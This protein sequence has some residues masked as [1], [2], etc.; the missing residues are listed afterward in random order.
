M[1]QKTIDKIRALITEAR[2]ECSNPNSSPALRQTLMQ[3]KFR[4]KI[5][6]DELIAVQVIGRGMEAFVR[7]YLKH[8]ENGD[9]PEPASAEQLSL[10]PKTLRTLVED[11]NCAR[12]YVPSEATFIPLDPDNMT[13][14]YLE[15][16][17]LHL[18]K[19]G[20]EVLRRSEACL[21][22]AKAWKRQQK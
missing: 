18:R 4:N 8:E 12:L 7:E 6:E 14:A 10:W 11:V 13:P 3:K 5:L 16:A 2:L 20:E 9:A 22:L 15:E 21:R 1:K 17:A 19:K